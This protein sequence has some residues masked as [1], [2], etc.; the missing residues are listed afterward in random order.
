MDREVNK[1][2]IAGKAG[3]FIVTKLDLETRLRTVVHFISETKLGIHVKEVG[4]HFIR[5]T[6]A[7][8]FQLTAEKETN[9]QHHGG[10]WKSD[11]YKSY[12][13]NNISHR[14]NTISMNLSNSS[15]GNFFTFQSSAST[16]LRSTMGHQ[17]TL[18]RASTQSSSK[19]KQ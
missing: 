19:P 4:C 11:Y 18:R 12:M 8:I 5:A 3:T 6:F 16:T 13:R 9:I 1:V 15:K 2:K 17:E 14:H 10:H 7:T